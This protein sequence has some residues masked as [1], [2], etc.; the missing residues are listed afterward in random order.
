MTGD[1]ALDIDRVWELMKTIGFAMLVTCHGDK[2][3]ARLKVA[4]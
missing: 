3:R 1:N 2:L 4:M